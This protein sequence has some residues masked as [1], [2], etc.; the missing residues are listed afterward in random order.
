MGEREKIP[1]ELKKGLIFAL[2]SGV[3][4]GFLPIFCKLGLREGLGPAELL[5]YRF[6]IA[7]LMMLAVLAA[8]DRRLLRPSVR[9]VTRGLIL[10]FGF[11]GIQSFLYFQ[12]LTYIPASTATLIIYF[13]PVTVTVLSIA[14]FRMKVTP[15]VCAS[16]VLLLA[17]CALVFYDAFAKHLSMVGVGLALMS[18]VGFSVYLIAVQFF[19][20]DEHPLRI[21]FYAF[22]A[23]SLFF[24]MF[25]NPL[26]LFD[27]GSGAVSIVFLLALVPTV[28]AISLLYGAIG[29]IGSAYTSI[30]S[31]L[32]P[33]VTV[34]LAAWVLGENVVGIQVLGMVLIIGGIM[35]PNIEQVLVRRRVKLAEE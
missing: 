25:H 9:S 17:G 1:A 24:S 28:L 33:V 21:T 15:G 27:K 3:F 22:L 11:Y 5:T 7:S 8:G 29:R 31:T 4:Y 12:S 2:V 30:F 26:G 6:W 35:V 32:E 10:G 20:R 16:L 19:L 13:Y 23:T 18:M 34:L 14:F